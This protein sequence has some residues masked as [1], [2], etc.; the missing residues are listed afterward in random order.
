MNVR[1]YTYMYVR[2]SEFP[3]VV[4]LVGHDVSSTSA[5]DTYHNSFCIHVC[6]I[7][8]SEFYRLG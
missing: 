4:E 5:C 7:V 2:A 1:T 6:P 8:L 3:G